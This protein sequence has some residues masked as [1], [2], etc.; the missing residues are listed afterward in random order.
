MCVLCVLCVLCVCRVLCPLCC[1]VC[2]CVCGAAARAVP[3]VGVPVCYRA[4]A[5]CARCVLCVLLCSQLCCWSVRAGCAPVCCVPHVCALRARVR[6]CAA[7]VR[8]CYVAAACSAGSVVLPSPVH[9]PTLGLVELAMNL[10]EPALELRSGL[11]APA[12]PGLLVAADV[13]K[14]IRD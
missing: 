1:A 14:V 9:D 8:V 13:D 3:C 12:R 10:V 4:C 2:M 6:V 7:S 11:V 5:L